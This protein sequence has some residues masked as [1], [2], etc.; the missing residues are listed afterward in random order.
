[1]ARARSRCS[2]AASTCCPNSPCSVTRPRSR[3]TEVRRP[4]CRGCPRAS[5][6]HA[7]CRIQPLCGRSV[8]PPPH[9]LMILATRATRRLPFVPVALVA[10]AACHG[11]SAPPTPPMIRDLVVEP[12]AV[13]AAAAPTTFTVQWQFDDP[14]GDVAAAIV[15]VTDAQAAVVSQQTI[16]VRMQSRVGSLLTSSATVALP[17]VGDY[18]FT[19]ELTDLAG[20]HS[21]TLSQ[22]LPAS[23]HPWQLIA[24]HPYGALV[25][26]GFAATANDA[27]AL[28]GVQAPP[29][30]LPWPGAYGDS[31]PFVLAYHAVPEALTELPHLSW[32][33]QGV[34]AAECNGLIYSIGG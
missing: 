15:T 25:D 16:D 12:R 33:R 29:P 27:Y 24:T 7:H 20:H 6:R 14:N 17:T 5:R 9:A 26:V 1:M 18:T 30:G 21:N 3:S 34:A 31:M 22:L 11:G 19:V 2:T 32:S 28:G 10:L 4:G 23:P 8:S 13:Y